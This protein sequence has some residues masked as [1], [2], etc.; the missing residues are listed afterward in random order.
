MTSPAIKSL[1]NGHFNKCCIGNICSMR[2]TL[3]T[4]CTDTKS[5]PNCTLRILWE[6]FGTCSCMIGSYLDTTELCNSLTV[7]MCVRDGNGSLEVTH[8]PIAIS[9]VRRSFLG[10]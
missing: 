9:G 1:L 10:A 7:I 4:E 8:W 2:I 3:F 6:F 5:R